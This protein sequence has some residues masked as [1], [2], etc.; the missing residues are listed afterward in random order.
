MADYQNKSF[1][2]IDKKEIIFSN[3]KN[4]HDE[5]V[6]C[7]KKIFHPIFDESL[8]T[9]GKDGIIKLWCIWFYKILITSYNEYDTFY[10]KINFRN[11]ILFFII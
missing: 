7:I 4:I 5:G 11:N 8:L 2:I 1:K 10:Y 9:A 3:F 6:V